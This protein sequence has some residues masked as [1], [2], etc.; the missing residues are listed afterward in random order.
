MEKVLYS[1]FPSPLGPI[2]LAS[3]EKGICR[4]GIG[5]EEEAFVHGLKDRFGGEVVRDDSFNLDSIRQIKEYLKGDRRR[6]SLSLDLHGTEF[7][8]K[9][10]IAISNIPYGEVR[11]YG[12]LA[13]LAGH[14][15][16]SRAVGSACGAN[17]VPIIIPCHRVVGTRGL[18]GYGY[19]LK[20]KKW[21]LGLEGRGKQKLDLFSQENRKCRGNIRLFG[22]SLIKNKVIGWI[23]NNALS[24]G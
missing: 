22:F 13:C 4:L 19:D 18:G 2:S 1:V 20:L 10:W 24:T 6:F 14:P 23:K 9:V 17:P 8:R 3:T 5:E 11:S 16:A 7:Q 12:E 21:L 15:G